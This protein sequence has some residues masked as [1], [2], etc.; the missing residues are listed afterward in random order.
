MKINEGT[1][2][3]AASDVAN[4]LACQELTQLDL[5]RARGTLRP[6]HPPQ[7]QAVIKVPDFPIRRRLQRMH[8]STPWV[9]GRVIPQVFPVG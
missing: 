2:R 8:P 6:P 1:L 7:L 9:A 4:F 5:R 3:V